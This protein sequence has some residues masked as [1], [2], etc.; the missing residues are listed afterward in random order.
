[1]ESASLRARSRTETGSRAAR[2]IRRSAAIPAVLYGAGDEP[3]PIQIDAREL[4]ALLNQGLSENT[5]VTLLI[6]DE[7]KADRVTLIREVQRDPI[8][9]ELRHIDFVQV[10]LK[11][12]ITVEVPIRLIGDSVGAKMGGIV[13]QR[14]HHVEI[15]C[16]P[17]EIP[18]HFE[19]DITHLAIGESCHVSDLATAGFDV[20]TDAARTVV[21]VAPPRV[22]EEVVEE[23]VVMAAEPEVIGAEEPAEEP[24]EGGE[25]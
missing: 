21:S 22:K 25:G 11:Q 12:E 4:S 7:K 19:L 15:R 16:L 17:T 18:E 6:D 14:L 24:G 2:R 10:D 5:L 3:Q 13:E 20:H 8:R 9:G 23:E 1:M